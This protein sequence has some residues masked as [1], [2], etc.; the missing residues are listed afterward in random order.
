MDSNGS[1]VQDCDKNDM[2]L[3]GEKKLNQAKLKQ[4]GK[5][6]THGNLR[7]CGNT[8][9]M[10]MTIFMEPTPASVTPIIHINSVTMAPLYACTS[11][12]TKVLVDGHLKVDSLLDDGSKVNLMPWQTFEH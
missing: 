2:L 1:S 4:Q 11:G 6:I 9:Y 8:Y 7:T 12:H 10:S 3:T 5:A